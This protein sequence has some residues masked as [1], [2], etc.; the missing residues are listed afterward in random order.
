[1]LPDV[2]VEFVP[3]AHVRAVTQSIA[4]ARQHA[5]AQCGTPP[6]HPDAAY[7][8]VLFEANATAVLAAVPDVRLGAGQVVRYRFFEQ[9]GADL[10][11]RPF[12]AGSATDVGPI[13]PLLDW[14]PPPDSPEQAGGAGPTQDVALLYRHFRF[15]PTA[16]GTFDYWLV[17]EEI[18]ASQ[19]W[20]HSHVLASAADLSQFAATPGWHTVHPIE[21]Y[22]PAVVREDGAARLAVLVACPLGRFEVTLQQVDIAADQSLRYGQPIV[23]A[24]G[25]RGYVV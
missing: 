5:L 15:P 7:W 25:P 12:V 9:R 23:V 22:E 13:R 21:R 1:M 6:H 17:L 3:A 24:V 11:V 19:R 8:E 4:E 10:R 16:I 18:W 2:S 14:H 20:A